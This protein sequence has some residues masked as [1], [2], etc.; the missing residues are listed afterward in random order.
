[1][2]INAHDLAA[3]LTFGSVALAVAHANKVSGRHAIY[4]EFACAD[5]VVFHVIYNKIFFFNFSKVSFW[6][7]V[8]YFECSSKEVPL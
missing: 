2:L 3:R 5:D 8:S 7:K 6:S 4:N 1:M